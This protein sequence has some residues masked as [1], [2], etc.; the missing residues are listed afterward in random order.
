MKKYTILPL[1]VA[2]ASALS[3][4]VVLAN[5]E[6]FEVQAI[7]DQ[8]PLIINSETDVTEGVVFSGYARYGA[9]YQAGDSKLVSPAGNLNGVSAGRLGNEDNG[10]EFQIAKAFN[11]ANGTIWDV[12]VMA[13]HWFNSAWSDNSAGLDLKKAYAGVTNVFES[14]PNMYFWAGRDFHQR[15]QLGLNDYFWMTHDGQGGGFYNMDL[16]GVNLDL[17]V[18]GAVDGA[19][20]SLVNDNGKYALTSKLHGIEFSE[21]A[22]LSIY[23][24]YGFASE[25]AKGEDYYDTTAYQIA[26]ELNFSG[27][28]LI[29]R[30]SENALDSVYDLAEGRTALLVNFDGSQ[31]ITDKAAIEYLASY[32]KLEEDDKFEENR[33]NYNAIV[34]PT[35]AWD[36]VHSTW[37]E[38]GYSVVDYEDSSEN[39]SAW[40]VTLSQNIS[41][42]S[43]TWDRPM[44]RFYATVGE[45]DN[46]HDDSKYDTFTIGAMWEAWW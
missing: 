32:Q 38:A 28:R 42:G 45:A 46:K 33:I 44:L 21:T 34:R 43:E 5:E 19:G 4:G 13:E 3:S 1:S 27:Q 29:V 41:I 40:K 14:Q 24:N 35:Y 17:S 30:Y 6:A 37:L 26:G 2:I 8:Q 39:N 9:A 11:G 31:A 7:D 18:V 16:G 10:G 36:D 23:A 25:Q 20:G 12:V 22:N 15:P